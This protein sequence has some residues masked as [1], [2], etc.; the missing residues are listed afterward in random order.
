[1][2]GVSVPQKLCSGEKDGEENIQMITAFTDYILKS[3]SFKKYGR[4]TTNDILFD[5]TSV[6]YEVIDAKK[7]DRNN[8]V[9]IENLG[10]C[11]ET[12]RIINVVHNRLETLR[13]EVFDIFN[14]D[15]VTLLESFWFAMKEE[16]RTVPGL[17]SPEWTL[18]GFQ[19]ND[20]TTDFRSMGM[21]GLHQLLHFAQRKADTAH[22]IL[23]E[24]TQP[25]QNFPF[26]IIGINL[27]RLVMELLGQR[28]LHTYII[29]RF[30]NLTVDCSLAYLEGPSNDED[31]INYCIALVHDVYCLV[32]EEFYLVWVV[33]K[34]S[35]IMAFTELYGEVE[36]IMCDKFPIVK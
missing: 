28:R 25:G 3:K 12:L 19:G 6:V 36:K 24:F 16:K 1:M 7:L 18:L 4:I 21:L 34:P 31:C 11:F 22:L 17:V 35:S 29:R 14:E 32:Y 33:R 10:R 27:S 30:G 23:K 9:L 5:V 2:W 8:L 26:A 13:N 20:P 15:H